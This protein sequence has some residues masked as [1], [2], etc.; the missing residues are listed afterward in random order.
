VAALWAGAFALSACAESHAEPPRILRVCADPNNLPFTNG[1]EEGFENRIA[2]LIARELGAE[3]EYTWWAQRRGFIRNTL[4]AGECDLVMAIPS[5]FE[6]ALATRP[7]Y[8]STYVFVYRTDAD[9]EVRSF[10]DPV[11]HDL[12]VGV[13]LIGDDYAN[14]PPAHALA[15]RGIIDNLVGFR[16]YGDYSEESPPARLIDAVSSGNIDVAVAWGPLAGYFATRDSVDLEIVP[17]SPQ[18]DLPFLPMV[19]DI[20]LGVRREDTVLMAELEA[21]LARKQSEID[22]ILD[23]YGVPRVDGGVRRRPEQG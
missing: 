21:I 6:L 18:I 10:D 2:E 12:R 16:I 19:Y 9:F 15:S 5:S 3:L 7:Y 23:E 22:A 17:V 14:T 13:H 11:L 20:S 4:R 8:R 1:R